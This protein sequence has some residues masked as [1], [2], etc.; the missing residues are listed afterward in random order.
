MKFITAILLLLTFTFVSFAQNTSNI[1]GVAN[2]RDFTSADLDPNVRPIWESFPGQFIQLR[3]TL[4]ERQIIDTL[5]NLEANEQKISSEELVDKEVTKKVANPSAAE[6]KAVYDANKTQIGDKTLEEIRPQII[7]FLK[8]D[9]EQKTRFAFITQLKAKYKVK[10]ENDVTSPNLKNDDALATIGEF[11]ITNKDFERKNALQL[12]EYEANVAEQAINSLQQTMDSAL[13]LAESQALGI[14]PNQYIAKEITNKMKDFSP[15]EEEKL[16]TELRNKLYT[17]YK[18]NIFIKEP[19]PFLQSIS[20]DDDPF[21]GKQNAPVTVIMF[22][23]FQCPACAATHP[24]LKQVIAEYGDKIKFIVRDFPLTQIHENAFNAA[25][26]AN[27][28]N[29]QGKY[30]EYTELLYDNN[31]SLD[32]ESLKKYATE[33]GLDV[34]KF[35]KDFADKT[36]AEEIRKDMKDGESYGVN[37]TPSIFVNGYKVRTLSAS[38]FRKAIER[39]LK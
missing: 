34:K 26:A 22:T 16:Q 5:L 36:L 33:A 28:A 8:Q 32:V 20:A 25:L 3:K 27:A 30:F 10:Y 18:A 7:N 31:K 15:A 4:L 12:Y 6:I 29:K 37:S 11:K 2:G 21:Y 17:K 19:Q 38:A 39:A 24:I 23:D 1:L 35:E 13:I 14:P 9:A